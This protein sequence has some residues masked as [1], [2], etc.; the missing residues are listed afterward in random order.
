MVQGTIKGWIIGGIGA[1]FIAMI[2]GFLC[3]ETT[4]TGGPHIY[5]RLVFGNKVG[6]FVT[7]LYWCGVWVC[8]PIL[9]STSIDYLEQVIGPINIFLR[10][11]LEISIVLSLTLLNIRG[12]KWA[13][14]LESIMVVIKLFP[15]ILVPILAFY[16]INVDNFNTDNYQNLQKC[17]IC[18]F[19]MK[20]I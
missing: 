16:N 12:I 17:S 18:V 14:M 5:I 10:F 2:F 3:L 20:F 19:Y 8:N 4:K 1:I 6:F 9:I 11:F 13:G 15:L 7:W